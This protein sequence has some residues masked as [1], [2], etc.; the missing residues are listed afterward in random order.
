MGRSVFRSLL[1][2]SWVAVAASSCAVSPQPEPPSIAAET[3]SILLDS[4]TLVR[5]VGEPGTVS[6]AGAT[7]TIRN[8]DSAVEPSLPVEVA[9]DADGGFVAIVPG[10]PAEVFRLQALS[11]DVRSSRRNSV[12]SAYPRYE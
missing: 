1:L 9:S 5:V 2:G 6:P 4:D 7:V 12:K 8:L 3:I 10:M 11:G